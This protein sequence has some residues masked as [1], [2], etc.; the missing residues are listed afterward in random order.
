MASKQSK[1]LNIKK[2]RQRY[3]G[4]LHIQGQKKEIMFIIIIIIMFVKG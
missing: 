2:N 3:Y 1:V 4:N